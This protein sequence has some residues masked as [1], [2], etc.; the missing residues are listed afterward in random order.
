MFANLEVL[1]GQVYQLDYATRHT[2]RSSQAHTRQPG[3]THCL[4]ADQA[5]RRN[6]HRASPAARV[7]P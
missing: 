7:L 6:V 3:G 2:G 1:R 5:P 4:R